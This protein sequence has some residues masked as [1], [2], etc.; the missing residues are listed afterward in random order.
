MDESSSEYAANL[1]AKVLRSMYSPS[2]GSDGFELPLNRAF[3]YLDKQRVGLL[4]TPVVNE[5]CFRA[6][7]KT[8]FNIPRPELE[9]LI[10]TKIGSGSIP[11]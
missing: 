1:I 4:T 6:V 2:S 11:Y 3:H 9:S 10:E 7:G 5:L 8:A